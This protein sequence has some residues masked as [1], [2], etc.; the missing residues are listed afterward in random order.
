M[1][2][3]H[4]GREIVESLAAYGNVRG[5]LV[6]MRRIDLRHATPWTQSRRRH[7]FPMRAGIARA[8]KEPIVGSGPDGS[9]VAIR[10]REAVYDAPVFTG[11][12]IVRA[13][14]TEARRLA[15]AFAREIGADRRPVFATVARCENDVETEVERALIDAIEDERIRPIE[16]VRFAIVRRRNVARLLRALV[17]DG[18]FAAVD[19]PWMQRI[20]RDVPILLDSDRMEVAKGYRSVVAATAHFRATAF[21]LRAEDAIRE[22]IVGNDV[23]ELRR[24]LIVPTAPGRATVDRNRRALIDTERDD[25]GIR[26]IDPD[27]MIVV[28][29]GR[30]F[31][32]RPR[33]AAVARAP[34]RGI[35]R[36]RDVAIAWIGGDPG[37]ILGAT[38]NAFFA[39]GFL[40]GRTGVVAAVDAATVRFFDECE[41]SGGIGG[42]NADADASDIGGQSRREFS[43]RRAA[44]GGFEKTARRIGL[45]DTH[46]IPRPVSRSPKRR[47]D[48]IGCFG[49]DRYGYRARIGIRAQHFG[50]RRA[51]VDGPI[52]SAF[53]VRPERVTDDGDERAF[54]IARIDGDALDLL[55]VAQTAMHPCG[56]G[57]ARHVHSVARGKVGTTQTFATA[58]I[59]DVRI[60]RR[61][62]ERADRARVSRIE[63]WVPRA[64]VVAR[65]PNSTV[66]RSHVERAADLRHARDRDGAAPA[67]R[68]DVTPMKRAEDA[69][70]SRR[71]CRRDRRECDERNDREDEGTACHVGL[72][73][74]KGVAV[75]DASRPRAS[76][77]TP[78]AQR[79]AVRTL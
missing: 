52:E 1:R 3:I 49:I 20:G 77:A 6:E 16:T 45:V 75:L 28:A 25:F 53:G 69:R 68:T 62:G 34:R 57:V 9:C 18:R 12:R 13:E 72:Q 8:P 64:T 30:A 79:D 36:I 51:A 41:N 46:E 22:A 47:V 24:R 60:R 58:G 37:E 54:R 29:A 43:P 40:P 19:Q 11:E 73:S 21:L 38:A 55:R 78:R 66:G 67:K 74:K 27:G 50:V 70:S 4:E 63:D 59:H 14:R 15:R 2:T 23:I 31:D 33:G 65:L 56:T 71:R 44:V 32:R 61:D 17:E 5:A 26:G 48:D 76:T 42:R 35:G 39:I 7:V 10:W